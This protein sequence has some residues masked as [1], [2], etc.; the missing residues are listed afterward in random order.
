MDRTTDF[1]S[2]GEGSSPSVVTNRI[3]NQVITIMHSP[4]TPPK[5]L[6]NGDKKQKE[7]IFFT[8]FYFSNIKLYLL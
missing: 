7:S 2:V 5:G 8:L 6:K 3:S 4:K 1:G